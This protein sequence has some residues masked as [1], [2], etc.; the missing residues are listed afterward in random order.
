MQYRRS[1]PPAYYLGPGKPPMLAALP[2]RRSKCSRTP[3]GKHGRSRKPTPSSD[4]SCDRFT[5][6]APRRPT[7][8]ALPAILCAAPTSPVFSR[9]LRPP[10][11]RG[12]SK[13]AVFRGEGEVIPESRALI[14]A[15]QIGRVGS[16]LPSEIELSITEPLP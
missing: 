2:P 12:W 1:F 7:S 14:V 6:R 11:L 8:S 16:Y 3:A 5:K 4:K 13:R 10:L 15:R 9:S